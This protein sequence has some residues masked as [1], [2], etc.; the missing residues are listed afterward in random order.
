MNWIGSVPIEEEWLDRV[1][2][3]EDTFISVARPPCSFI[4]R[5]R[6]KETRG[7]SHAMTYN[8]KSSED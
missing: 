2:L 3:S 8:A 7:Q 5:S 1:I 6:T 4:G